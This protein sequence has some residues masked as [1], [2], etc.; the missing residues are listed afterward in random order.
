MNDGDTQRFDQEYFK[1]PGHLSMLT[2]WVVLVG[3]PVMVLC[4]LGAYSVIGAVG[5][6]WLWKA[7]GAA[8]C[9][10]VGGV[11]CR[12]VAGVVLM[13]WR[14]WRRQ[15]RSDGTW[16]VVVSERDSEK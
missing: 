8:V 3:L 1:L 4:G 16:V 5:E 7:V 9:I 2:V 12:C 15:S 10:G 14:A 6:S 13:E 11:A